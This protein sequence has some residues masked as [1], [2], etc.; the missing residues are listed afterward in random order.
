MQTMKA[1]GCE[2][3]IV[4]PGVFVQDILIFHDLIAET[5]CLGRRSFS[6]TEML[7]SLALSSRSPSLQLKKVTICG[8]LVAAAF[9][10][11]MI[12]RFPSRSYFRRSFLNGTGSLHASLA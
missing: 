3:S 2:C 6:P 7:I 5:A 4:I 12:N 11:L 8:N 10:R 9:S 1:L